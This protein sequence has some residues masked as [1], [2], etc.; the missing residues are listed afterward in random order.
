MRKSRIVLAFVTIKSEV[1]GGC[2]H[3]VLMEDSCRAFHLFA[4]C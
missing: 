3:V 2:M 1:E 4:W